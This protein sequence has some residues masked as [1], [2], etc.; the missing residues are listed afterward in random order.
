MQEDYKDDISIFSKAFPDFTPDSSDLWKSEVVS[1]EIPNWEDI[2]QEDKMRTY[3][4]VRLENAD[5]KQ[6][7][8]FKTFTEFQSLYELLKIKLEFAH[9]FKFPSKSKF[10]TH[11]TWTKERRRIGFEEFTKLLTMQM[12]QMPEEAKEFFTPQDWEL[13]GDY[14]IAREQLK[15]QRSM[16]TDSEVS[17]QSN[18]SVNSNLSTL[19]TQAPVLAN[20]RDQNTFLE[21]AAWGNVTKLKN[22]LDK[23]VTVGCTDANW[24]TALHRAA[25]HGKEKAVELLLDNCAP[26]DAQD[27]AGRTPLWNACYRMHVGTAKKLLDHGADK[28]I[29]AN[30]ETKPGESWAPSF[31]NPADKK[32]AIQN[33]LS[34]DLGKRQPTLQHKISKDVDT[35]GSVGFGDGEMR[36]DLPLPEDQQVFTLQRK[37][38]QNAEL[39]TAK[40]ELVQLHILKNNIEEELSQLKQR[41][42]EE[43][44]LRT[45]IEKDLQEL[46]SKYENECIQLAETKKE[47]EEI[48]L[49][50]SDV[51]AEVA[52]LNG[53]LSSLKTSHVTLTQQ[54]MDAAVLEGQ[55][56][57]AQQRINALCQE[58]ESLN[59]AVA[60]GLKETQMVQ[61]EKE[62]LQEVSNSL[63]ASLSSTTEQ[64]KSSEEVYKKVLDEKLKL[65]EQVSA[66]NMNLSSM[67]GQLQS[68]EAKYC[69]AVGEIA[70]LKEDAMSLKTAL[71]NTVEQLEK[72]NENEKKTGEERLQLEQET[73]RLS[74]TLNDTLAQLKLSE[75]ELKK[76]FAEKQELAQQADSL[77]SSLASTTGQLKSAEKE[78]QKVLAENLK[79]AE[80]ANNLSSKLASAVGQLRLTEEE[81]GKALADKMIVEKEKNALNSK[82]SSILT[83]LQFAEEKYQTVLHKKEELELQLS[84]ANQLLETTKAPFADPT[85]DDARRSK[86]LR[87][88]ISRL[89]CGS[90]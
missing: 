8:V 23:G 74:N 54:Q 43:I 63:N 77:N 86:G 20:H 70:Q 57:K 84:E 48:S 89:L 36:L 38:Q 4:V 30:D 88:V 73:L 1:A 31:I 76:L 6:W 11:S 49:K 34:E 25:W 12:T 83:Q 79:V 47:K 85:C 16:T 9:P 15:N 75:E 81:Y 45:V 61:S 17:T 19:P 27:K 5:G 69:E 37:S 18:L 67:L 33:F 29:E 42:Q 39:E 3:Y 26:I 66:L 55:L 13:A 59:V 60:A 22:L 58:V 32:Q 21:E 46:Q 2:Q 87:R 50:L 41:Q 64:L 62:K 14:Q 68:S 78:H 71:S 10:N 24:Q 35:D 53:E 40:S 7:N 72:S 44:G 56:E 80:H 82:L 52:R 28:T 90:Y 65:E 51:Q